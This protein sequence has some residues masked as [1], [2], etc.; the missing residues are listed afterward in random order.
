MQ[1][2]YE[3]IHFVRRQEIETGKTQ[4]WDCCNKSIEVGLG[5]IKWHGSWRQYCFF[6]TEDT[7]FSQGCLKDI[8]HFIGQLMDE[9]KPKVPEINRGNQGVF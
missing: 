2:E 4:I 1:T 5:R 6:P 7:L 9:R 8:V 3:Y